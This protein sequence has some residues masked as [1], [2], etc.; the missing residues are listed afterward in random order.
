MTILF[1]INTNNSFICDKFRLHHCSTIVRNILD[2]DHLSIIIDLKSLVGCRERNRRKYLIDAYGS[3]QR[4]VGLNILMH[5]LLLLSTIGTSSFP[6][7]IKITQLLKY[8]FN[9][10]WRI[11][12]IR[13]QY[14]FVIHLNIIQ[15][16]TER[17]LYCFQYF[18]YV[19]SVLYLQILEN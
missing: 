7:G 9:K 6:H 15:W 11:T 16:L 13:E 5:C 3:S 17:N 12:H 18:S 19:I 1:E 14:T 10:Y 4:H 8:A 2:F